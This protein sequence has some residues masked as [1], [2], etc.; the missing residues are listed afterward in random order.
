[1]SDENEKDDGT[2]DVSYMVG[3]NGFSVEEAVECIDGEIKS[4]LKH[5]EKVYVTISFFNPIL[6]KTRPMYCK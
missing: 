6:R 2:I 1:M 3:K 4:R 5:E